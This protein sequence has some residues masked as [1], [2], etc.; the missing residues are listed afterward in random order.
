MKGQQE[1]LSVV[2]I[3]GILIGVVGSVYF[4]GVPLVQKNKDVAI[5]E[6][7][8]SFVKNLNDKIKFV[9]N[10]GG[11]DQIVVTVP[12]IVKFDPSKSPA[13]IYVIVDT[14]GTIYSTGAPIPL[15]HNSDCTSTP[16]TFGLSDPEVICVTSTKVGENKYHTVYTL[17]YV[18]LENPSI[19]RD[20]AIQL[21]GNPKS[22]GERNTII[23]EN[24]GNIQST[25]G[26]TLISTLMSINII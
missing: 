11:R 19:V 25:S 4:W 24:L 12:G 22:G 5:L 10:N 7:A 23:F 6:G 20:Y 8:E 3:S 15:G 21:E 17:K 16:G 14:E 26:R 2:L 1:V 13:E 18:K 9:A